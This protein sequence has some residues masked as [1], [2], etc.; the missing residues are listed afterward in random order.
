[1]NKKHTVVIA[2]D[3]ALMR[4]GLR[5]LL[6]T[7]SDIEIVGEADNGKDAVQLAGKL[8][9]DLLLLD[10]NMPGVGGL[11]AIG[12]IRARSPEI[13]ILV[14]TMHKADE[15]LRHALR[16][17]ASGYMLKESSHA[18]LLTAVR[19]VLAGKYYLSPDLSGQVVNSL[20]GGEPAAT[21][22][23]AWDTL[24][25]RER[26]ILKLVAEG[27]GNKQIAAFLS[28]S[29]KTVEK[30]R[31]SLMHKLGLRNTAML[32]AYAIERGIV[33]RQA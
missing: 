4:A 11:E 2:E 5:A 7:E 10:L 26:G 8:Q 20:L 29:I 31:S 3:H 19:T 22:A 9:P 15:Y 33:D 13:K 12:Q 1:M 17:G 30:H 28:I 23:T 24:T 32:T 18:E 21:V 6:A 25:A 16:A 14:V 27:N